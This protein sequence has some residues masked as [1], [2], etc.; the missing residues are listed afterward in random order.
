MSPVYLSGAE[1][2][3][4]LCTIDRQQVVSACEETSSQRNVHQP[5]WCCLTLIFISSRNPQTAGHSADLHQKT[6]TCLSTHLSVCSPSCLPAHLSVSLLQIQTIKQ[7]NSCLKEK[8][9]SGV[10]EF[11]QP[12]VTTAAWQQHTATHIRAV[13]SGGDEPICGTSYCHGQR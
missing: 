9:S 3:L 10:D 5:W 6:G 1:P 13:V 8:V 7:S 12:E 11:R 4:C 2:C